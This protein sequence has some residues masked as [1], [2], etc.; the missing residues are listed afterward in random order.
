[1]EEA[2][3]VAW[4]KQ[5]GDPVEEGETLFEMET[6]KVVVDT[7]APATGVLLRID[8]VEGVAKLGQPIGW[9][10]APGEEIPGA[11]ASG[12]AAVA[13]PGGA[14]T[15]PPRDAAAGVPPA[16]PAARRRARELGV[17][18]A[19]VRGTGPGGRVTEKDVENARQS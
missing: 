2:N 7:P 3:I 9:I 6:D 17:D 15:A 14:G 12:E 5:A 8:V 1:M 4:R 11:R 18:L 13:Q 19:A 16:S 10:G